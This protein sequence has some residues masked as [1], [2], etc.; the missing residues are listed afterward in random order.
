MKD[1][2][3]SKVYQ[4]IEPSPVVLLTLRQYQTQCR[5]YALREQ[6]V[7]AYS[8]GPQGVGRSVEEK[9]QNSPPSGLWKVRR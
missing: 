6:I 4:L 7:R 3:L 1:L 5:R 2:P 8:G 9:S